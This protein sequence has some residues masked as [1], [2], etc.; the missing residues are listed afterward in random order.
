MNTRAGQCYCARIRYEFSG[1]PTD[2]SCCHCSIC[3]RLTGTAFGTYVGVSD[4]NLRIVKGAGN[5]AHYDATRKLTTQFCTTCGA[6]LFTTHLD[7]P[8][9][10][11]ISL[12]TLIDDSGIVPE[13]HQFVG[14]KAKW[15]QI[16]D[17]LPQFQEFN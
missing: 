2:V 11:Y 7:F 1:D 16:S 6:N 9:K 10:T 4:K 8:G 15:H 12:G 3:R 5:L 17:S 14:S 13:C